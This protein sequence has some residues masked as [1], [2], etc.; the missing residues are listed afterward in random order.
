MTVLSDFRP[1]RRIPLEL[2]DGLSQVAGLI[3]PAKNDTLPVRKE[4]LGGRRPHRDHGL[5][6]G[7]RL[8]DFMR[9]NSIGLF[10]PAENAQADVRGPGGPL[11]QLRLAQP[12]F[13]TDVGK[14]IF[15]H[16][17]SDEADSLT[18]AYEVEP[19][20]PVSLGDEPGG[21]DDGIDAMK[22]QEGAEEKHDERCFRIR[23]SRLNAP[24]FL[25]EDPVVETDGDDGDP[26]RLNSELPAIVLFQ[27]A[28]GEPSGFLLQ[29]RIFVS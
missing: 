20:G 11:G 4:L 24:Q 14:L 2:Q 28:E 19:H 13:E 8:K 10:G 1:Q 16:Q 15:F 22:G 9:H 21:L 23:N 3:L 6:Q 12:A 17:C 7:H 27:R 26:P 5:A 18:G 29:S 25:R